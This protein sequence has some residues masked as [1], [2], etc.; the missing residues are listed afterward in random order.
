MSNR[1]KLSKQFSDGAFGVADVPVKISHQLHAGIE[2]R[3]RSHSRGE[4]K[5]SWKRRRK[6]R[7]RAK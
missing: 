6:T 4:D 2:G 7:W 5:R 3:D 1:D